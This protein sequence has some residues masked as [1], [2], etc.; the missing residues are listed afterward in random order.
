[1]RGHGRPLVKVQL[2]AQDLRGHAKELGLG[3]RKRAYERL[4]VKPTCKQKSPVY[5]RCQYHGMINKNSSDSEVDQP[6][7]RVLQRAELEK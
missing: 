5:W 2:M 3:T 6:E 7:L 1:M 4:L